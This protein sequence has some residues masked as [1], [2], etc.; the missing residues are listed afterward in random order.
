MPLPVLRLLLQYGALSEQETAVI[1]NRFTTLPVKKDEHIL[2]EGQ[3]C[4]FL[5]F[6]ESGLM[7]YYKVAEDGQE[8]VCDFAKENEWVTQYQSFTSKTPSPLFIKALEPSIIYTITSRH[9]D[10]LYTEIKGFG[11]IARQLIEKALMDMIKRSVEFQNLRAEERYEKMLS[12]YPSIVQRVPQYYVASFLGIA[13]P[14][15]SRIRKNMSG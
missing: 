6:I 10:E 12:E 7:M 3:V 5:G 1:A 2:K 9:L 14:S 15:L 4:K 13:P 11:N 8:I